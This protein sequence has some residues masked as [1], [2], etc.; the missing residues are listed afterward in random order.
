MGV[1]NARLWLAGAVLWGFAEATFFFIVPDLLLT[2]AAVALGFRF[3]L[4]LACVAAGGAVAG[5]LIMWA[6]GAN[7]IEAARAFLVSVPLI[8][9][10]LLARVQAE[11]AGVWP[12][13][14]TIGAITGA[15]Y[16]I[17]AAEA[18]AA[19]I[20][21]ALFA[22][23]SFAARLARFALAIGLAAMGAALAARLGLRRIVPYG[24]A[25]VWAAIYA[26][27]VRARLGA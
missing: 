4:R 22:V 27:Y 16:K 10:D 25:L 15:P 7:D 5:G 14:L 11:I 8:G 26:V 3:A 12:V 19:A 23:V 17:Y 21:P 18:G 13:D 2:A 20:H 1:K 9:E 24:L 6:F